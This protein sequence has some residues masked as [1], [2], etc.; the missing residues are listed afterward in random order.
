MNWK[1]AVINFIMYLVL[2]VGFWFLYSPLN[3]SGYNSPKSNTQF[4]YA[5]F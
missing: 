2:L 4:V 3:T 1:K 5:K